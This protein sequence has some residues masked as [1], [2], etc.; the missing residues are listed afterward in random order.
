MAA[1]IEGRVEAIYLAGHA[2]AER[3]PVDE[4]QAVAGKGL[5]GDRYFER[6]GTFGRAPEDGR[7]LTLIESEALEALA[8]EHGIE[9][10][11]GED[12]RNVVTRGIG[13]N[14][15]VGKR[16]RVGEA[17]CYGDRLCDPCRHLE[18]RTEPGVLKGLAYRGGLRANVLTSGRIA[19]GDPV[20]ELA[21]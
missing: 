1:V 6:V 19:V 2:T 14:D 5:E 10:A 8:R 20:A 18:R 12:G 4:A 13:L 11:P 7:D 16:F 9:L 17:E 21:G 3:R 15:L